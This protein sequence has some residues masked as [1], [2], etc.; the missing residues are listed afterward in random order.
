LVRLGHTKSLENKE[1]SEPL[2]TSLKTNTID[3]EALADFAAVMSELSRKF[4]NKDLNKSEKGKW[5]ELS[6]LLMM[7]FEIAAARTNSVSSIPGFLTEHL[8][9]RLVKKLN[10]S[11]TP[12][13]TANKP[14]QL[15]SKESELP[16]YEAESL[17]QQGREVVLKTFREYVEKGQRDFVLSFEDTYTKEDWIY[18]MKSLE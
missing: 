2:K 18:L 1:V 12:K 15:E 10:L 14:L 8:R 5:K 3:D 7:E 16:V 11:N 13:V 17:S 9:R 6:D 4:T